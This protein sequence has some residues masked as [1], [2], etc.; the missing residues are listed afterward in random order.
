MTDK[1]MIFIDGSNLFHACKSFRANYRVSLVKLRETLTSLDSN[2]SLV[3][4]Y[5]YG[6]DDPRSGNYQKQQR[7]HN[8]LRFEGFSVLIRHIRHYPGPEGG[9][10]VQ[11]EK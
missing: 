4:A 2:R 11:K 6:A 8:M 7:F 1:L 5:Y 9:P 3:R 10:E